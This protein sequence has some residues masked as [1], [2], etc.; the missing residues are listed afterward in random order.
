MPSIWKFIK[1]NRFLIIMIPTIV[2]VH[3]GWVMI[4]NNELFVDKSEKKDL[5]IVIVS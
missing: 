4:Q 2:G 1:E 3:F 5:P